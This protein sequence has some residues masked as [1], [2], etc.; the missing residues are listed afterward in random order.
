MGTESWQRTFPNF[1]ELWMVL[2]HSSLNLL[3]TSVFGD[4]R[5]QLIEMFLQKFTLRSCLRGVLVE[6]L[7]SAVQLLDVLK[8]N[9]RFYYP[10]GRNLVSASAGLSLHSNFCILFMLVCHLLLDPQV[11]YQDMPCRT[12][13]ASPSGNPK[14]STPKQW[15]QNNSEVLTHTLQVECMLRTLAHCRKFRF[16]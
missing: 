5:M 12:S 2:L 4:V 13:E 1:S 14:R 11:L 3:N 6:I 15:F 16:S 10:A 8:L 7:E 9:G